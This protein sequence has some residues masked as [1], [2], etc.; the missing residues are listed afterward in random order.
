MELSGNSYALPV[1]EAIAEALKKHTGTLRNVL[2]DDMFTRRK[3][4]EIHPALGK[5]ASVLQACSHLTWLDLRW[6]G[7]DQ[8]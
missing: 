8:G 2:F 6:V 5:F 1:C 4:P 7:G 3:I